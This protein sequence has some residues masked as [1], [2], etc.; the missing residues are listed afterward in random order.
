MDLDNRIEMCLL[1]DVYGSLLTEKQHNIMHKYYEMD[2]SLAEIGLE[3][4]ISRQAVRDALKTAE[5]ILI[6]TEEKLGVVS[7]YKVLKDLTNEIILNVEQKKDF[8]I[9]LKKLKKLSEIL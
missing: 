4:N 6:E 5:K 2:I 1:L 7:R 9:V 3:E 8:D